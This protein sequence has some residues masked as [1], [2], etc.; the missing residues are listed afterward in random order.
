MLLHPVAG[1]IDAAGHPDIVVARDMIQKTRQS[2]R[3]RRLADHA[4]MQAD[5]HHAAALSVE[6]VE[7]VAQI[8]E[9]LVALGEPVERHEFISLAS[10]V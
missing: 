9:E 1:Y 5:A 3:P 2:S 10:N 7:G 8:V 6:L 4:T